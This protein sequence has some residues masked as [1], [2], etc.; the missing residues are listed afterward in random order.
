VFREIAFV[1]ELSVSRP[2]LHHYYMGYYIHSCRKMRY[3]GGFYPSELLCE[4]SHQW[5]PLE[6]CVEMIEKNGGK[7]TVFKPAAPPGIF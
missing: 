6:D 3:K 4:Y 5:V 1:R 7:F 2:E